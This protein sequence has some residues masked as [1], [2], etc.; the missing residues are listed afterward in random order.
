MI[1]TRYSAQA[2]IN[3]RSQKIEN[4]KSEAEA[5]NTMATFTAAG[6]TVTDLAIS[7]YQVTKTYRLR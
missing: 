6:Y 5:R 4:C 3:G 1:E 2:L 7:S